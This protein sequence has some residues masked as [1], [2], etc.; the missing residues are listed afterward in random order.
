MP[1]YVSNRFPFLKIGDQIAFQNGLF[2][3]DDPALIALIERH[4]WFGVHIHPR[5]LP[6]EASSEGAEAP[7]DTDRSWTPEVFVPRV[8]QGT[9]GTR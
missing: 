4:D 9:R 5:D 7:A 8:R 1:V 3:T 2:E 6:T